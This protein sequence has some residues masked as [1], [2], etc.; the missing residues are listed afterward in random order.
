MF[1]TNRKWLRR[2]IHCMASADEHDHDGQ[3]QIEYHHNSWSINLEK[4]QYA[5]EATRVVRDGIDA[6][7]H[8]A[9]GYHVNLVTHGELGYP[10][11][12]LFDAL[13][14]YDGQPIELE[15][16]KQCG[17]GGHVTRVHIQ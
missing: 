2:V 17:C 7:E 1:A 3:S 6:V 9:P 14:E 4:P 15:C 5:D 12:F 11:T 16:I 8:T 13:D 10:E